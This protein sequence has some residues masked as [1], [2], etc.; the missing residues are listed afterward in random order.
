MRWNIITL[1]RLLDKGKNTQKS[2]ETKV[3]EKNAFKIQCPNAWM[4]CVAALFF[5]GAALAAESEIPTVDGHLGSCSATFTVR[6]KDN[7]P[8]YNARIITTFRYG[9]LGMRKMSLEVGTDSEGK[10]RVAGLPEKRKDPLEFEITSGQLS[11]K[12]T[13]DPSRDCKAAIEVNLGNQ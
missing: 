12:V 9:P 5:A 6:D 7:K 3:K 8:I 10:A 11:K 2:Q 1:G 4:V 13:A